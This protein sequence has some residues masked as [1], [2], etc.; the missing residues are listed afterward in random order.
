MD[1]YFYDKK[2]NIMY[3]VCNVCNWSG[4]VNP[5]FEISNDTRVLKLNSLI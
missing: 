5:T 1:S 4:N 2:T 3:K